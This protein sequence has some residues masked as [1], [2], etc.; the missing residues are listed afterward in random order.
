M[1]EL[2]PYR[3]PEAKVAETEPVHRLKLE[4]AGR[5]RRF[6][7]FVIDYACW[8]LVVV[9][10]AVPYAAYLYAQGGEVALARMENG[11]LLFNMMFNISG[12]LLYYI[13]FEGFFG[14]TI[15]KLV[16]GTR[17]V[18]ARGGKPTLGHAFLRTLGRFIPFEPLSI[19][20]SDEDR[21]G[22]HD[23]LPDTYVVRKR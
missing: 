2:N 12:I 15:G 4:P 19:L 10:L 17:V 20:F 22:W 16:T 11:G 23:S 1:D 21:R 3:A 18:D 6:F 14:L 5:W 9:V 7:N 8:N 13:P